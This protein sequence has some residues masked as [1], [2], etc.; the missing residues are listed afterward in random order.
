MPSEHEPDHKK[1]DPN[2]HAQADPPPGPTGAA[3]PP[4]GP[5]GAASVDPPPGPTG[6]N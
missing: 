2:P 5:T 3:D 1:H 6:D 4:P